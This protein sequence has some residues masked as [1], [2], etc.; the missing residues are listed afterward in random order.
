MPVFCAFYSRARAAAY[1]SCCLFHTAVLRVGRLRHLF[2]RSMH[3]QRLQPFRPGHFRF[4]SSPVANDTFSHMLLFFGLPLLYS[5]TL[6]HTTRRCLNL[7]RSSVRF[8][9]PVHHSAPCNPPPSSTPFLV[10]AAEPLPVPQAQT[11]PPSC[12]LNFQH[13]WFPFAP[14]GHYFTV[15]F[16]YLP[17]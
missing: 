17:P 15:T 14:S 13:G 2:T 10:S 16:T 7:P 8:S 6:D 4:D 5:L 3:A 1:S 11:I 12:S 9:M